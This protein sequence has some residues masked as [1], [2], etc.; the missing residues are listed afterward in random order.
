MCP[1]MLADSAGVRG[2][3]V[4]DPHLDS[5]FESAGEWWLA[6]QES[7]RVPGSVKYSPN[8]GISLECGTPLFA[9]GWGQ[10]PVPQTV[11]G[12]LEF[13]GLATLL[14]A[15]SVSI[16]LGKG[17]PQTLSA[18]SL[19]VGAS[20]DSWE[21]P[22]TGVTLTLDNLND[23][24]SAG[25]FHDSGTSMVQ[26]GCPIVRYQY[27]LGGTPTPSYRTASVNATTAIGASFGTTGF[28]HSVTLRQDQQIMVDFRS[29]VALRVT[30]AVAHKI[31]LLFSLLTGAPSLIQSIDLS[32]PNAPLPCL[33]G[34]RFFYARPWRRGSRRLFTRVHMPARFEDLKANL[35]QV[36]NQWFTVCEKYSPVTKLL[37]ASLFQPGSLF[38]EDRFLTMAQAIEGYCR[39]SKREAYL[40]NDEFRPIKKAMKKCIPA[41]Y[42]IQFR[43][44]AYDRIGRL[45]EFRLRDRLLSLFQQH[46]WLRWFLSN[47]KDHEPREQDVNEFAEVV[48]KTRNSLTHVESG[49]TKEA[50]VEFRV[51]WRLRAI[52]CALLLAEAGVLIGD[53]YREVESEF[54]V[55]WWMD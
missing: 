43:D 15:Q 41:G 27:D 21:S 34:H 6:G 33:A 48:T 36:L 17:Q 55:M 46:D 8:A 47:G 18:S 54:P 28:G 5:E 40:S 24:V 10:R 16:V 12:E 30:I 19:L 52:L 49:P 13:G 42:P 22:I 39:I 44:L 25:P 31:E 1:Q 4:F 2:M 26:D 38:M 11:Q 9:V 50:R 45:N 20:I 53:R 3:R 7:Y 29:S 32:V 35:G 14:D 51:F 37:A 23:W